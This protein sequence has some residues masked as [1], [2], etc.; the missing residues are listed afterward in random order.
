MN[1][2]GRTEYSSVLEKALFF[3]DVDVDAMIDIDD[4]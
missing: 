1:V 2:M 3:D 4:G